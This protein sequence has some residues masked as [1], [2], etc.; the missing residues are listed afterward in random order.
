MYICINVILT[1][2]NASY[3]PPQSSTYFL[4][5]PLLNFHISYFP[6]IRYM[7]LVSKLRGMFIVPYDSCLN[8]FAHD[9]VPAYSNRQSTHCCLWQLNADILHILRSTVWLSLQE[10]RNEYSFADSYGRRFFPL[11]C[12][13]LSPKESKLHFIKLNA[14]ANDWLGHVLRANFYESRRVWERRLRSP[15][16][17]CRPLVP[18]RFPCCRRIFHSIST[19][20]NKT[21]RTLRGDIQCPG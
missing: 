4:L 14:S 10:I 16:P 7:F 18:Q 12:A 13:I 17:A 21:S 3:K 5:T 20:W 15:L 6:Y 2:R 11:S 8:I 19:T 9:E 1:L